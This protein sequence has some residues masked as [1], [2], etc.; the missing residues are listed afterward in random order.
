MLG[1]DGFGQ[2]LRQGCLTVQ[3]QITQ[4]PHPQA[5]NGCV[6]CQ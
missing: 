1:A 6:N 3:F 2:P 4:H 5:A